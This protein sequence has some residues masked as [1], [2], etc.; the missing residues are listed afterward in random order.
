MCGRPIMSASARA[1]VPLPLAAGPS[2]AMTNPLRRA[3]SVPE[4]SVQ[5]RRF[6]RGIAYGKA[7]RRTPPHDRGRPIF[8]WS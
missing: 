7:R 2:T 3:L 6:D 5:A 1:I 4:F 8:D